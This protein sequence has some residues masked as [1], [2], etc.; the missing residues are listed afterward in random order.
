[1]FLGSNVIQKEGEVLYILGSAAN[2]WQAGASLCPIPLS[3]FWER[4]QAVRCALLIKVDFSVRASVRLN[5]QSTRFV[6]ASACYY[7]FSNSL[8]LEKK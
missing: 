4:P 6:F 3:T 7:K 1:M 2:L 5:C 8:Y